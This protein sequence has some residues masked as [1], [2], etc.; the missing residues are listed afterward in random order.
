MYF[1]FNHADS[2]LENRTPA[3][4]DSLAFQ[5]HLYHNSSSGYNQC[6]G[7]LLNSRWVLTAAHCVEPY[8]LSPESLKVVLGEHNR[9]ISLETKERQFEVEEAHIYPGFNHNLSIDFGL[10]KLAEE[11][12]F[13]TYPLIRPICLPEPSDRD[14]DVGRRGFVSGWGLGRVHTWY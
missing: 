3:A 5:A 11:V 2:D 1:N 7:S 8:L 12:Q 14:H 9:K 10:L 13:T 4:R 6:A